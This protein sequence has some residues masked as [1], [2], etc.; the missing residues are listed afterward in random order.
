[1]SHERHVSGLHIHSP[2]QSCRCKELQTCCAHFIVKHYVAHDRRR[3]VGSGLSDGV[4]DAGQAF[5]VV[6][7]LILLEVY[8]SNFGIG[9]RDPQVPGYCRSAGAATVSSCLLE[10]LKREIRRNV[11][12]PGGAYEVY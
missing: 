9:A 7:G 1:M 2:R 6:A 4:T 10:S 8:E 12:Q 3:F 11:L 5:C